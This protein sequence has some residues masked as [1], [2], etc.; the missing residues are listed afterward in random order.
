LDVALTAVPKVNVLNYSEDN[1][2]DLTYLRNDTTNADSISVQPSTNNLNEVETYTLILFDEE[3]ADVVVTAGAVPSSLVDT[4]ASSGP[5]INLSSALVRIGTVFRIDP[6][7]VSSV[8]NTKIR[9]FGNKSGATITIPLT[10]NPA[11]T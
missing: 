11:T 4:T 9:V 5:G 2:I 8:K 7:D 10:V 1:G 3:A 6:K